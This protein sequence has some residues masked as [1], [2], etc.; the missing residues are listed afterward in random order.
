MTLQHGPDIN[1]AKAAFMR[2]LGTEQEAQYFFDTEHF[3][4]FFTL[5]TPKCRRPRIE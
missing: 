3:G 2:R 4:H 1:A 5:G